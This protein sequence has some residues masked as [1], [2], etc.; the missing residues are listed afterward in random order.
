NMIAFNYFAE[1]GAFEKTANGR[2]KVNVAKMEK[3][4]NG[5]SELILTLQG[6]GDYDGVK[7]LYA[8]KGIIH[9]DLQKD[10]DAL[11]SK[12][13]P[14]DVVFEQGPQMLGL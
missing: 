2:Y 1:N 10:L 3:A 6:N 5:L 4:M 13:I 12:N 11:K 9:T 8:E 14:V 7:K